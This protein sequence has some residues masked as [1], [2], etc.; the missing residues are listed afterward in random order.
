M[1]D[2]ILPLSNDFPESDESQWL[3]LV[4]K[5]LKGAPPEKLNSTT[6]DGLT[7]KALYR[8]TDAATSEDPYGFPGIAPFIRGGAPL[9]DEFLPWDIRQIIAHPDPETASSEIMKDLESGVSSIELRVDEAGGRGV[10][11]RHKDDV[12]KVLDGV[13]LDLAAIGLDATGESS[14]A[15]LAVAAIVAASIADKGGDLAAQNVAF[16]VDPIGTLVR[17][18]YL[19]ESF[20][21]S[22]KSALSFAKD[23]G[24]D[25]SSATFLRVDARPAHEAGGSEAQEL[26]L[27]ATSAVTYLRSGLEAGMDGEAVAKSMLF[28]MSC[29]ADVLREISKIKAARRIW[30]KIVEAFGIAPVPMKIQ[31]I[32]SRRMLTARDPWTNMLRNSAACFGAG[33]GGADIVTIRPFTDALGLP[34]SLGRRIARNTQIMAQE[35]SFLGRVMDPTGG[36]WSVTRLSEDMAQQAWAEFQKIEAEGGIAKSFEIGRFQADVSTVRAKRQ[37]DVATRR[38]LVTGVSDFPN[39]D[40]I[41][42][43]VTEVDLDG[44]L[45]KAA[46]STGKSP[47]GK[48]WSALLSAAKNGACI[49]DLKSDEHSV[50][51]DSLWPMRLSSPFERLRDHA[52]AFETKTGKKAKVLL[53]TLGPQSEHTARLTFAQN[54][55]A[56]GG[57]HAEVLNGTPAELGKGLATT[58]CIL[59]CL[60]GS[61]DRYAAEAADAARALGAAGVSRLYLAGKPGDKEATLREAGIDE[62]IH[63]GVDVVA[64]LEIALSELGL[65]V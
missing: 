36:A 2:D 16:N 56:A 49:E 59:A 30:G 44:I 39:L 17:T 64:C 41:P 32:S 5:A 8:E 6:S 50:E 51:V 18:G 14:G 4:D 31:S 40:E 43:P 57:I 23:A 25:F 47:D 37:K 1:A 27:L 26:A 21:E 24:A 58:G 62:F 46:K 15:D 38:E 9:P 10:C 7:V 3:K 61:D 63:V 35:E 13:M 33:V 42:A 52:E 19:T 29:G 48:S 55:F 54:L 34:A 53:A 22:V 20:D 45:A 28:T 11:I 65:S 60:C 12:S